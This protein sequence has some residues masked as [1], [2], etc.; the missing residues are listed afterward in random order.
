LINEANE[1]IQAIKRNDFTEIK[2]NAGSHPFVKFIIE[3]LM[4]LLGEV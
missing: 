4:I 1:S 2:N 3:N